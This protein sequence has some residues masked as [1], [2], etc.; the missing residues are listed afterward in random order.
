MTNREHERGGMAAGALG[1][2]AVLIGLAGPA[3]AQGFGQPNTG[4]QPGFQQPG[5]QQPGIQQPGFQQP[6]FQQPGIQ[7][8]QF[9]QNPGGQPGYNPS[10]AQFAPS[11][12][13]AWSSQQS[14]QFGPV[15]MTDA[16]SPDG[17]YVSV[18]AW[19][20]TGLIVRVWGTYRSGPAGPNQLRLELQ[21]QGYLPKQLCLPAQGVPP[22]CQ[23]FP[24]PPPTATVMV[25]F[26][27]PSSF[28]S[29]LQNTPS[30]PMVMATRD[31]NPALLQQQ[32][33]P[34]QTLNL[35]APPPGP[36]PYPSPTPYATPAPSPAPYRQTC[37]DGHTRTICSI[38]G[39]RL[40]SSGGCLACVD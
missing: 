37:D 7:Q 34:Q 40:V 29:V 16:F 24:T 38:R 12:V 18:A 1:G 4:Q 31:P 5:F 35:P 21:M 14:S 3:T 15:Q 8:P 28:Q 25:T 20:Q 22:L 33:A 36:T 32:V 10:S 11:M 27:S 6:N 13:G 23:P 39:G 30:A 2:L 9:G 17:Q 26:T 19:Q